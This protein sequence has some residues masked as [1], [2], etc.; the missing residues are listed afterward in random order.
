MSYI[1]VSDFLKYASIK[2]KHPFVE[3]FCKPWFDL[4]SE[5]IEVYFRGFFRTISNIYDGTFLY[6]KVRSYLFV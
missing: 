2:E 1:W 4:F 6:E 5:I 3:F